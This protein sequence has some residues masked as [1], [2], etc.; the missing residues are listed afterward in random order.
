MTFDEALGALLAM[1]GQRV[2]V[3]VLDA[4]DSPH[5]A[6]TFGGAPLA[7]TSSAARKREAGRIPAWSG[8]TRWS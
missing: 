6:T 5:L 2:E 1:V 8:L 3:H 7:S 4:S